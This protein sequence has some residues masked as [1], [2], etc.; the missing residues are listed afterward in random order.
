MTCQWAELTKQLKFPSQITTSLKPDVV[1]VVSNREVCVDNWADYPVGRG[2]PRGL[3][4]DKVAVCRS[5]V[6]MTMKRLESN[7]IPCRSQLLHFCE[8]FNQVLPERYWLHIIKAQKGHSRSSWASHK[9]IF[10][11][12]A[13]EN[14]QELGEK[15]TH[16]EKDLTIKFHPQGNVSDC[17]PTILRCSKMKGAKHESHLWRMGPS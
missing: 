2:H 16:V 11:A 4:K 15:T 13:Q 5:T 8:P 10:S 3:Q 6:R 12:F 1:L 9:G 17:R 14:I 7:N